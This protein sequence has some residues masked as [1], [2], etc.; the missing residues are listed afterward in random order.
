MLI[1]FFV[2]VFNILWYIP[3]ELFYFGISLGISLE[4]LF[5]PVVVTIQNGCSII[6]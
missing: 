6:F 2:K 3:K 1:F 5:F 4:M